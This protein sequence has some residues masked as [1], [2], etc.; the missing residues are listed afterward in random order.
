MRRKSHHTAADDALAVF[1]PQAHEL[2]RCSSVAGN[3]LLGE[4]TRGG[5]D[6]QRTKFQRTNNEVMARGD[7]LGVVGAERRVVQLSN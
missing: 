6:G 7:S 4:G 5:G 1:L 3:C 2:H